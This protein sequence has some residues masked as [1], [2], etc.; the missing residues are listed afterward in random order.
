MPLF[1]ANTN[2]NR[3]WTRCLYARFPHAVITKTDRNFAG[4][5]IKVW[6]KNDKR[7]WKGKLQETTNIKKI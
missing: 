1:Y 7:Y 3:S 4:G 6:F 5:W 2:Y